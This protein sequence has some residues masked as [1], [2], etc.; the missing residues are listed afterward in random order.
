[1]ELNQKLIKKILSSIFVW[2]M[3]MQFFVFLRFFASD[4]RSPFDPSQPVDI[5]FTS[6]AVGIVGVILGIVYPIIDVLLENTGLTRRS[7]GFIILIKSLWHIGLIL[8]LTTIIAFFVISRAGVDFQFIPWIKF[9]LNKNVVVILTYTAIIS[10]SINFFN[11]LN[12]KFGP[13][14]LWKMLTGKFHHPRQ[15]ERIFMF[16]DLQ[17]STTHA[18]KL[19][20]IK[21]SE[22]IQDCFRDLSVVI[23]YKAEI[24]Q[25][26]GDEVVL[27]WSIQD[28]LENTNCLRAYYGYQ[29]VL[30]KKK[31]Y[32]LSK[33]G[34]VPFFK[35]GL[36]MGQVTIA[37]VGEIKREIAFHGDTLNTAAR[38]QGMCNEEGKGL[39]ISERLAENI[40]KQ[41]EFKTDL[42]G[43]VLLRGKE[44]KL[45]VY[46]VT[47]ENV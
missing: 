34:F 1:M 7:Y 41:N 36:N 37:E 10:F 38:I 25:Y 47:S 11:Q 30:N 15:E 46:S 45:N 44:N 26:V 13:G 3:A 4:V 2:V 17:S 27:S 42:I 14:N 39:L 33:Y 18:E 23:R 20:H 12:A 19:G 29:G 16:L 9:F 31:D 22:L 28:G 35:A 40:G 21:F 32:Y 24:Y 8:P 5:L 6:T 43:N